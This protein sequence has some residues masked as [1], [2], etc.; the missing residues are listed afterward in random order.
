MQEKEIDTKQE[1]ILFSRSQ[2]PEARSQ[3]TE[4]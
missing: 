2:K 4:N 3:I 1:L